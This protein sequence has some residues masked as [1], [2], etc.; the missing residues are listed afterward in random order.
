MHVV[1]ITPQVGR[2]SFGI[3]PVVLN[4]I[5][6][7]Q[8][9]GL[10]SSVY[11]CDSESEADA[12]AQQYNL[13]RTI[14]NTFRVVGPQRLGYSPALEHAIVE[15]RMDIDIIHQHGVWT[16]VS[17]ATKAWRKLTSKP[18]VIAPHGSLDAW[19]LR[20]SWWKKKISLAL[21][22]QFNLRNAS[23]L[24]ALSFQEA[25]GFREFGLKNPIAVIPNG[26]SAQW[27][28]ETGDPETFR[29][30]FGIPD[31]IRVLFYLGRITPKKGLPMFIRVMYKLR[32]HLDDWRF[33]VAGVDEFGHQKEIEALVRELGMSQFV[34]FVGPLYGKD[35]RDAFA[36]AELF[37]LPS[38]SEGA[39]MVVLESLGAGVPVLTTKAS[40]WEEL[41]NYQ[42]GWW[43]DIS[44]DAIADALLDALQHSRSELAEMG[45]HGKNLVSE[46]YTW[47]QIAEQ[48]LTLY[49]W[50][51]H[52]GHAPD[53]VILE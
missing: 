46:R 24:H 35:K 48:T 51:L 9:L 1:H 43:T 23:C 21:Y 2:T 30:K 10:N 33:I 18:T 36:T 7:Q 13:G 26:V 53:F 34:R 40:P 52:G 12:L 39:P 27:L 19:A 14:F 41:V 3:G 49:E 25:E 44:V 50:L 42:C 11:T 20:R 22:E 4:L 37:V 29:K 45:A 16:A 5:R 8:I 15:R 28:A 31:G 47:P 17:R 6:S 38:H 32:E